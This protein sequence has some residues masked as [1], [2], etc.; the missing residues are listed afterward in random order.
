MAV[1]EVVHVV[2]TCCDS[3]VEK[4]MDGD[5]EEEKD[6]SIVAEELLETLR[7]AV[8]A[9]ETLPE[10]ES[11]NVSDVEFVDVIDGRVKDIETLEVRVDDSTDV[12]EKLEL[13]LTVTES[14][15]DEES[16]FDFSIDKLLV[17]EDDTDDDIDEETVEL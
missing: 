12:T 7:D 6:A 8:G 15:T 5:S 9:A 11:L 10:W 14:D 16:D 13:T 3:V 4:L 17:R 1:V 2:D